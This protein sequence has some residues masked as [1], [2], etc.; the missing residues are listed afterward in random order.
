MRF[1]FTPEQDA[2]RQEIRQFLKA[3][4]PPE[5][6]AHAAEPEDARVD[7]AFSKK[8]AAKGWIG[9]PW[10]VEYGGQGLGHIER[11][12]YNEEMVYHRAPLG[13]HQFAERQ[14]GPSII[15][16]GTDYQKRTYLPAIA[17]AEVS[18]CIG[19]TEPN[20]GS[21]LASLQ[22]AAV[23]DGDDYVITGEKIYTSNAHTAT[24]IWL[25]VRT[26]REGAK[27]RGISVFIVPLDAPGIRIEPLKTMAGSRLNM[28]T[29]DH[30]R[31]NAREMVGGRDQGWYIIAQN[32]DFERSGIERVMA[33]MLLFE[34]LVA[35]AKA[36]R[37]G[38]KPLAD[39]PVVRARMAEMATGFRVGR[40]FAFRVAWLQ[41]QGK[42]A[43][44]EASMSKAFGADLSQKTAQFGMQL[45]GMHGAV[46]DSPEWSPL[47][48]RVAYN[49]LLTVSDSIR[50]GTSEIQR[51]I[52]ATRGLGLPRAD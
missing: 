10:P 31:V 16:N 4:L 28:V 19:Y 44:A 18:F 52:I 21:D 6:S 34:E 27:H 7:I 9:L 17:R 50:A 12:I 15:L 25:A 51:N 48:S 5:D 8:L 24:H 11:F 29:L 47:Q 14:M 38:N 45:L 46:L 36:T 13:Y 35:Y 2:F 39:D 26:N 37:R 41:S 49:Y 20:A 1:S 43:N 30:V 33:G 22:T 32:L 40:L 23:Q 3:E 42:A